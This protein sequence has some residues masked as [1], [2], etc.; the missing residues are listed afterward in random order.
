MKNITTSCLLAFSIL[1]LSIMA[2]CSQ[3]S[4]VEE[5]KGRTVPL[6]TL[7]SLRDQAFRIAHNYF[8]DSVETYALDSLKVP[9]W[10]VEKITEALSVLWLS[11]SLER[12][13]V[14]DLYHVYPEC[15]IDF[16]NISIFRGSI[17]TIK[18]ADLLRKYGLYYVP[19]NLVYIT[20]FRSD[21]EWNTYALARRIQDGVDESDRI[22]VSAFGY[23]GYRDNIKAW[24]DGLTMTV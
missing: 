11:K 17:D 3:T 10:A 8:M 2:G 21:S 19:S 14:I 12:D 9:Q 16:H 6:Q 4:T 20:Y 15:G 7:D 18:Y 23:G 5:P 22:L 13:S 1:A 24:F